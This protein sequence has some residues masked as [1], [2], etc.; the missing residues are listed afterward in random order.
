[1]GHPAYDSAYDLTQE[2]IKIGMSMEW[3]W[4]PFLIMSII[5]AFLKWAYGRG[6]QGPDVDDLSED[7]VEFRG[8]LDRMRP[9]W[10]SVRRR[11][12]W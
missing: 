8:D 11:K 12:G 5:I 4:G 1:M 3:Y 9:R 10:N 2:L 7:Y 6:I